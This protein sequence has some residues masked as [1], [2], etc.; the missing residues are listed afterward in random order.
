MIDWLKMLR[1]CSENMK[2]QVQPLFGSVEAKIG[3]GV[4]AGGDI[5]KQIDLAS[6]NAL[7]QTLKEH[8]VSCTVISEEAGVKQ[9]GSDPSQ[10]YVTVDPV[11]GTT[12]AVRGLP[13][14]DISIAASRK[15]MLDN[16][17]T[18]LVAE[19]L[20]DVTYSA[21]QGKGAYK[22]GKRIK[23]S[24]TSTLEEAVL[25]VDFSNFKARQVVDRLIRILE[26]T[27]HLRH[28]GAN[29]LEIC[30]VADGT[31]DGFIDI[32]G[33]LRVTD[34]AAAYLILTEAGGIITAP[35]GEKLNAPLDA[36]QRVS[37]ITAANKSVYEA[38]QKSMKAGTDNL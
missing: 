20:R 18:A 16:V 11:D 31:T 1:I 29:A 7:F 30:Y 25:G 24:E 36:T 37:F 22:N 9:I 4:G 6:E 8:N 35:T 28:L 2:K 23:P 5:K 12:N 34:L 17:E 33:K 27:G 21:E 19:V 13:F 38:I 26:R 10:F 32:R 14:M 3:F 15:P